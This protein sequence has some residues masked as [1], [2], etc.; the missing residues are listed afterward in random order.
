MVGTRGWTLPGSPL[1]TEERDRRVYQ[2]ECLRLGHAL[3]SLEEKR[4]MPLVAL[5]HFPPVMSGG[6]P[7]CFTRLLESRGCAICLYGH[8]H[9][10]DRHSAFEGV[11]NGVHYRLV[12]CDH[13][14]FSPV[15]VELEE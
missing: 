11:L 4:S 10:K 14:G 13:V 15:L 7:T 9:G 3:Q 6:E 5:I 8:L 1:F 12:S 2:R